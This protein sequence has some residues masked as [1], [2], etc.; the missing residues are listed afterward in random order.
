MTKTLWLEKKGLKKIDIS[1]LIKDAIKEV[2]FVIGVD[3]TSV[4]CSILTY[5]QIDYINDIINSD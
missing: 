5:R 4:S 2:P 3:I 1:I